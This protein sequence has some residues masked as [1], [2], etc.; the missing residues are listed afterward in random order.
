MKVVLTTRSIELP[1]ASGIARCS[2]GAA[3]SFLDGCTRYD[4]SRRIEGPL[5]RDEYQAVRGWWSGCLVG[6]DDLFRHSESSGA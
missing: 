5:A 2:S 6:S 4:S 3:A 1:A